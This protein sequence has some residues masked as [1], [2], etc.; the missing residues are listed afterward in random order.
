M[1]TEV[2]KEETGICIDNYSTTMMYYNDNYNDVVDLSKIGDRV[3]MFNKYD[4]MLVVLI[5]FCKVKE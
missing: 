1:Y 2:R 3:E 4:V 5:N